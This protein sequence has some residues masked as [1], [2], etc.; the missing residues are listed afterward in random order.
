MVA[1]TG[2]GTSGVKMQMA[3]SLETPPMR[4]PGGGR[5]EDEMRSE[6]PSHVGVTLHLWGAGRAG[7]PRAPP[8]SCVCFL[9]SPFGQALRPLL[10]S[11][12]IQPPGGSTMGR[13]N[14][15]S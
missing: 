3:G 2:E 6:C 1:S 7:S 15:Q 8:S 11:I 4:N 13:P 5:W 9:R 12:Q 10:D 14:G